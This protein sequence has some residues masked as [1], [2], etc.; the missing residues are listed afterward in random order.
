[1]AYRVA[2]RGWGRG[3]APRR[4]ALVALATSPSTLRARRAPR[5]PT[6]TPTAI[7]AGA[8]SCFAVL[9]V[10]LRATIAA[11]S[12]TAQLESE[13]LRPDRFR[14]AISVLALAFVLVMLC[15]DEADSIACSLLL[16]IRFETRKWNKVHVRRGPSSLAAR[17]SAQTARCCIDFHT[18]KVCTLDS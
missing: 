14:N 7:E 8:Q 15:F 13:C 10:D 4:E 3:D 11:P 16:A 12:R 2:A 18:S 1:M 17:V 6:H 9:T 5:A